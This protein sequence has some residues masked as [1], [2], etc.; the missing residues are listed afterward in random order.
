MD[1]PY[2]ARWR[3]LDEAILRGSGALDT[4]TREAL[5]AG[6]TAPEALASYAEKVARHAYRVTDEDVRTLRAAGYSED[7]I[8]EA[9][10]SLALGAAR[11]RLRAGLDALDALDAS[12]GADAPRA[13]V[14]SGERKEEG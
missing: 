11:T 5:A 2:A 13:E 6:P 3:R 14:A 12:R 7:Q 1:D 8:F 9:T 10:L 4:R